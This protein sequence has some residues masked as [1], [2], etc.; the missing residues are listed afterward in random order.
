[1]PH[2]PGA[3]ADHHGDERDDRAPGRASATSC[4]TPSTWRNTTRS[5]PRSSS[6]A[7]SASCSTSLFEKLRGMLVAWAEPVHQIAVGLDMTAQRRMA[8][9]AIG[10]AADRAAARAV[11]WPRRLRDGAA[12]AAAGAG[13]G[14][15]APRPAA[16]QSDLSGACRDHALPPVRRLRHCGRGRRR[17]G[18]GGAR[19]AAWSRRCRPVVRVLAPVPKIALYPAFILILGFDHASKIAL[20]VGG[21][22]VPDPARDLSG[23]ARGRA[24]AGL[25][26]AR[27]GHVARA[28]RCSPWC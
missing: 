6:S 3:R 17:A 11:A 28:R 23:R 27:G 1:M 25:V 12:V 18:R 24:Q 4:S 13:G 14:V 5:T 19:A 21:C 20:V 2:R 15:R 16:R 10:V 9:L 8:E 26:G 7:C 22:G